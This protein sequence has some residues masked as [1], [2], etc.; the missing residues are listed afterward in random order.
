MLSLKKSTKKN[1]ALQIITCREEFAQYRGI[2]SDILEGKNNTNPFIEFDWVNEWWR[3]LGENESV[4]I[5]MVKKGEEVIAFLPFL[6]KKKA[7]VYTYQFLGFGQANYMDIIAAES[8]L[9]ES[10][11]YAINQIIERRVHVVFYLHGLLES[12]QT[13]DILESYLKNHEL[14]YSNYRVVTPFIN[15][16]A[17]KLEK[18]ME[19]RKRLHRLDRREK[20]LYENADIRI[21]KCPIEEMD[22][23]FHLHDKRWQRKSDTSGFTNPKEKAFYTQLASI[24]S[25]ALITEIDALYL[26][27]KIIAFNYG[28]SC[29]GRSLGYVLGY[30]DDFEVFSPGRLLEKEKIIQCKNSG[31]KIFDLSIGYEAYKFD[32]NT[33]VDYTRRMVF[34]SGT[35]LAKVSQGLIAAKEFSIEKIKKNHRIVLFKRN[36]M[37]HFWYKISNLLEEGAKGI[38]SEGKKMFHLMRRKLYD[39]RKFIVYQI[40]K[41]SIPD[42]HESVEFVELTL[43]DAIANEEIIGDYMKAV[44]RKIYGGYKGYYPK[45]NLTFKNILWTNEKV[46][47]IEQISY[48]EQFK[49]S[50]IA[51]NNWSHYDLLEVCATIKKN[52]NARLLFV[53]IDEKA[54]KKKS[55]LE[56]MGFSPIKCID[57]KTV[58]GFD[59]Y[60]I[61]S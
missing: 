11:E 8:N 15:L 1:I 36:Q 40:D 58:F 51:F 49:K 55:L 54:K 61:T 9:S 45:G 7:S 56:S 22:Y 28:F 6:Y 24:N 13:P 10:I 29:R 21:E 34:S 46:L 59:K 47:R 48:H 50:S 52:S 39:H 17:I 14:A 12:E 44:C 42:L 20:R 5:T 18:Y 31:E 57:K 35:P 60:S 53:A 19:K 23:I 37:G 38:V 16:N 25:G 41:Q 27:E 3:F 43:S 32:W 26:N 4:E 2:W 33:G 30:D